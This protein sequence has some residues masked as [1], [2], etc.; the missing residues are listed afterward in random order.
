MLPVKGR[1]PTSIS[2]NRSHDGSRRVTHITHVKGINEEGA[3]ELEDVFRFDQ[4]GLSD[5]G[6]ILGR[7][8]YTGARPPFLLRLVREGIS[9][10]ADVFG[11]GTSFAQVCKEMEAAKA[12]GGL[13]D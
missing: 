4:S 3:I 6:K 1:R 7:F 2:K 13:H 11:P 9:L 10:P 5:Q 12:A 8:V